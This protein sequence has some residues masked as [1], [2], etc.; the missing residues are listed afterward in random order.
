MNLTGNVVTG[1]RIGVNDLRTSEGDTPATVCTW[2]TPAPLAIT[3]EGN[4]ISG[5][6]YGI[7]RRGRPG[8]R[9]RRGPEPLAGRDQPVRQLTYLLLTALALPATPYRDPAQPPGHRSFME[10]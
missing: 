8:H 2:A 6:Y 1:N 7:F 4:T 5:D 10:N 9:A 3:A